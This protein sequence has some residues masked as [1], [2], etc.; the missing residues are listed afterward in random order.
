MLGQRALL[1]E[2]ERVVPI[3]SLSVAVWRLPGTDLTRKPQSI[4]SLIADSEPS[5]TFGSKG[6]PLKSLVGEDKEAG[7]YFCQACTTGD[8]YTSNR[9]DAVKRHL[10][11]VHTPHQSLRC[12][13]CKKTLKNR[14]TFLEHQRKSCP[15]IKQAKMPVPLPLET[16]LEHLE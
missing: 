1:P 14:N 12:V 3:Y 2:L 8:P 16:K 4:A 13:L 11:T 6:R 10:Q 5:Q 9:K 7:K 15:Y